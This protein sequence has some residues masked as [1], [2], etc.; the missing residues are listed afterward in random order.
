V[1]Q[2]FDIALILEHFSKRKKNAKRI[3]DFS[4]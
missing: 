2:N 3:T 4:L 1:K